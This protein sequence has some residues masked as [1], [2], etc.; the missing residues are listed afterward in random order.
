[1]PKLK[2]HKSSFKRVARLSGTGKLMMRKMSVAHRARFK[3]KRAKQ[4]STQNFVSTGLIA[5]KIIRMA[6]R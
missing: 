4:L 1:M 6:F 2:T 5:K 3:S